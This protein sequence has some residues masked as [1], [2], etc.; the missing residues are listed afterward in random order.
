MA[1]LFR[2]MERLEPEDRMAVRMRFWDGLK[3]AEIA[4]GLGREPRWLYKRIDRVM[5]G[6]RSALEAEGVTADQVA[7]VLG[8]LNP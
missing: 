3:I 5:H 1:A 4:H 7:D 2:A 6:L 8:E